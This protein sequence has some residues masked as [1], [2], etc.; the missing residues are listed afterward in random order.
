LRKIT[1]PSNASFNINKLI[2]KLMSIKS[3]LLLMTRCPCCGKHF[4]NE[5]SASLHLHYCPKRADLKMDTEERDR[6]RKENKDIHV[7]HLNERITD[8]DFALNPGRKIKIK[9]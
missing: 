2:E 7:T 8:G 6:K 3:V 9:N 4:E 5:R 1:I